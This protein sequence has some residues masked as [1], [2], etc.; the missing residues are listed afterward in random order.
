MYKL[1]YNKKKFWRETSKFY[2]SIIYW[3]DYPIKRFL[4]KRVI[5]FSFEN[6]QIAGHYNVQRTSLFKG[7][8]LATLTGQLCPNNTW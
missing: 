2:S 3:F 4:K 1:N 5:S 7:R 6:F 8:G